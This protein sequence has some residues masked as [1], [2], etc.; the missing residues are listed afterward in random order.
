M[1]DHIPEPPDDPRPEP[2]T[3]ADDFSP[4]PVCGGFVRVFTDTVYCMA[5]C[6]MALDVT[7]WR[8]LNRAAALLRA[9]ERLDAA[10]VR[11]DSDDAGSLVLDDGFIGRQWSVDVQYGHLADAIIALAARVEEVGDDR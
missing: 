5:E 7:R 4:C 3:P 2:P 8:R 9:C 1:S 6:G 11:Y 10:V